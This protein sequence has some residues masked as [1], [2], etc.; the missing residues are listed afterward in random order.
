MLKKGSLI[1]LSNKKKYVVV[2]TTIYKNDKLCY[3]LNIEDNNDFIICKVIED[4]NIEIIN[5]E[6][7]INIFFKLFVEDLKK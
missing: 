7:I 6:K 5:D 1:T 3:I 4:S 2:Y